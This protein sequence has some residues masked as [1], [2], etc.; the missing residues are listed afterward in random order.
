MCVIYYCTSPFV[1]F[2][3]RFSCKII[4]CLCCSNLFCTT[5]KYR[6]RINK[7]KIVVS[8]RWADLCHYSRFLV[9]IF[10]KAITIILLWMRLGEVRTPLVL[11]LIYRECSTTGKAPSGAESAWII[12]NAKHKT[13]SRLQLILI[14][15][16]RQILF[17]GLFWNTSTNNNNIIINS[18]SLCRSKCWAWSYDGVTKSTH[19]NPTK[20]NQTPF[21]WSGCCITQ[22]HTQIGH[23][24]VTLCAY[25]SLNR[26]DWIECY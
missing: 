12:S 5:E 8:I 17:T 3:D 23:L 2:N 21:V 9:F 11:I 10:V 18:K 13:V 1:L 4:H 7:K 20:S 14:L 22:I 19:Q 25:I 26:S 15:T 24:Y 6:I 16:T